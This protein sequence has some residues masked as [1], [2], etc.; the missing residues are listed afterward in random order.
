MT[1]ELKVQGSFNNV[2]QGVA[3]GAE[4]NITQ[5]LAQSYQYKD[6]VEQIELHKKLLSLT[7]E[8]QIDE[9]LKISTKVNSLELQ[10]EQF[11][12]DVLRLAEQFERIEV[13]TDRL[14]RAKECFDKGEIAEARAI[15]EAESEAMQNDQERL[16]AKRNE[17]EEKIL[18]KLKNSADEYLLS[19]LLSITDYENPNRYRETIEKF[20]LSIK[21]LETKENLFQYAT[22]LMLLSHLQEAEN[23]YER[24]LKKFSNE[25]VGEEVVNV[26]TNLGL[27]YFQHHDLANA[28][29]FLTQAYELLNQKDAPS[30]PNYKYN[31]AAATGNLAVLFQYQEKVDEAY[32]KYNDSIKLFESLAAEDNL[33]FTPTLVDMQNNLGFLL[34]LL[35][36]KYH[37]ENKIDEAEEKFNQASE[38]F[39]TAMNNIIEF[40]QKNKLT[41]PLHSINNLLNNGNLMLEKSEFAKAEEEYDYALKVIETFTM[42]NPQSYLPKKAVILNSLG[43]LAE[44]QGNAKEAQKYFEQ[45][46]SISI[47]LLKIEWQTHI[48][49]YCMFLVN[50][51]DSYVQ[52]GTNREYSMEGATKVIVILF[53]VMETLPASKEL[54][55]KHG[56][57]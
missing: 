17:Y 38:L 41:L 27:V 26:N 22:L 39:K 35:F 31:L 51:A 43:V 16:L 6:L 21:S 45:A 46:L 30:M 12:K 24:F 52:T 48:I 7:P 13:N 53:P 29:K 56:T 8:N 34:T 20:E 44:R 54:L 23:I 4:V 42:E 25:L 40:E 11:K 57:S 50:L 19:A 9:R 47:E 3:Q 37:S 18:P 14:K 28:E 1:G 33:K 2:V 55:Q 10:I 5:V 49:D 36:T 32:Q 15:F